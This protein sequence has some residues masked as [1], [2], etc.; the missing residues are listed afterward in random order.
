MTAASEAFYS[1][2]MRTAGSA[3]FQFFFTERQ[4]FFYDH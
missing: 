1:I 4:I 2:E 3:F